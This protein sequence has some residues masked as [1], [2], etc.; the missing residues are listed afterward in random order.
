[1]KN[2]RALML[3]K[4]SE[5]VFM[6]T[7]EYD[8]VT[9]HSKGF[10][11]SSNY[12]YHRVFRPSFSKKSKLIWWDLNTK[13]EGSSKTGVIF[14]LQMFVIT[15]AKMYFLSVQEERCAKRRE[16][17]IYNTSLTRIQ[18]LSTGLLNHH[19]ENKLAKLQA[20]LVRNYDLPSRSRG[21][22]VE[23]GVKCRATSVVKN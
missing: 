8:L 15:P 12:I 19:Q 14:H 2:T 23:G 21:W 13:E 16:K 20:T 3:R 4:Y 22:S 1:M 7:I 5:W 6:T 18:L 11:N 9:N 10:T 17:G